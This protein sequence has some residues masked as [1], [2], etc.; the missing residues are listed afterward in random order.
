MSNPTLTDTTFLTD[1]NEFKV[2]AVFARRENIPIEIMTRLI[3][4][5]QK[6]G[7]TVLLEKEAAFLMGFKVGYTLEEMGKKADLAIILGGDGTMLGICR[8]LVRFRIP[9]VGINTGHLG[10]I[11]DIC[12]E[13][14]DSEINEILEGHYFIDSRIFLKAEQ[15]REGKLIY[16]GIALNEICVSRGISGGMIDFSVT[17]N[18]LPLS[19]QRADGIIFSTPTGSTA[20]ALSVGGPLIA[21]TVPCIL[22]ISV[23][24]HTLSN[25]PLIL[26]QESVIELDLLDMRDAGL[27][28]D[29]QDMNEIKVGDKLIIRPY[30]HALHI[31]HP[32]SHNFF[33]TINRKL[34]WNMMPTNRTP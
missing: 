13:T 11:T 25:R 33:D 24:P 16:S 22:M 1:Q 20:Y 15:Y 34:H 18:K 5:L 2:V 19:S 4:M 23:A 8:K 7:R 30:E 31:L 9:V 17:V 21:P 29:M 26:A 28:Y 10:F 6:T 27:Y 14:M 3:A 32:L 12:K